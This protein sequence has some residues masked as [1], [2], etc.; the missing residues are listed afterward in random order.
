MTE[1]WLSLAILAFCLFIYHY[2]KLIPKFCGLF[3]NKELRHEVNSIHA[4]L[5]WNKIVGEIDADFDAFLREMIARKI[6]SSEKQR[7]LIAKQQF[8]K[9]IKQT[10]SLGDIKIENPQT[11]A[12]AIKRLALIAPQIENQKLMFYHSDTARSLLIL[13][14]FTTNALKAK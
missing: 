12:M 2:S 6:T 8:D 14:L 9:A 11:S 13:F 10:P 3:V 4:D 1:A 7:L 5:E